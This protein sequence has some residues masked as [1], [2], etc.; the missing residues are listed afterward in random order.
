M[1]VQYQTIASEHIAS[2]LEAQ[3]LV[4]VASEELLK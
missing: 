1:S 2:F 4:M 3:G